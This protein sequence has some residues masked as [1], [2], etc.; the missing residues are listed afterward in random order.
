MSRTY[1]LKGYEKGKPVYTKNQNKEAFYRWFRHEHIDMRK[2]LWRQHRRKCKLAL[3]RGYDPPK[4]TNTC[5]W[6]TW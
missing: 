2:H 1:R 4:W 3:D 5:G 6:E